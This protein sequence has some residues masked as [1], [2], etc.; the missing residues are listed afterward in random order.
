MVNNPLDALFRRLADDTK[1]SGD[2]VGGNGGGDLSDG[3]ALPDLKQVWN[4][5][6]R[7]KWIGGGD[8]EN[9]MRVTKANSEH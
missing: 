4:N 5:V 7:G 8:V 1:N 2:D 3:A 6:Q 9:G